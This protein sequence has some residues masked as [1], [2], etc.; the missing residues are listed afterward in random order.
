MLANY[1]Y[2]HS[3]SGSGIDE[4]NNLLKQKLDA[5]LSCTLV[6]SSRRNV[7][8]QKNVYRRIVLDEMSVDELSRNHIAYIKHLRLKTFFSGVN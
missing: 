3:V 8:R 6:Y 7:C 1:I 2:Y 5:K 4:N